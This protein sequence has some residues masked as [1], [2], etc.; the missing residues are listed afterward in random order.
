M[1]KSF[2]LTIRNLTY[3]LRKFKDILDEELI[4]EIY[5]NEDVIVKMISEDQLYYS[6]INGK[7]IEIASYA[8]YAQTTI[9]KK[10]RK[11]QPTTRVTLK[12][13]GRL[14]ESLHVE[15][16][17]TGFF[18]KADDDKAKYLLDK[19]GKTIFRLTDENLK[20]LLDDYIR[21]S[22]VKKMKNYIQNG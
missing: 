10:R 1:A 8:P 19:Y 20:A 12:D 21:P 6:G 16:N 22:L 14:Y 9:K 3:R 4:K 17:N 5:E 11:G 13:T 2:N 15:H 7:G 18:V